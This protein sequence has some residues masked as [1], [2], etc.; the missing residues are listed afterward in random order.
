MDPWSGGVARGAAALCLGFLASACL[1][2][3]DTHLERHISYLDSVSVPDTAYVAEPFEVVIH[4]IGSDT[5]WRKGSD[6]VSLTA[7]GYSIVPHDLREVGEGIVCGQ[8]IQHFQHV[9]PLTAQFTGTIKVHITHAVLAPGRDDST[10]VIVEEV[11]VVGT[12]R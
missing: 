6:D 4:T 2:S 11:T 8:A 12:P 7:G 5:C 3:P 10:A 1:F 9:I